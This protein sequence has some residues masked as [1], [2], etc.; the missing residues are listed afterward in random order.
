MAVG[1]RLVHF[2]V[3]LAWFEAIMGIIKSGKVVVLLAGRYA[4]RKAIVVKPFDEGSENRKFGHAIVAGI[5][6]YPR[7]VTKAMSKDKIKKRTK[8]K[9]FV[10]YVN[11]NHIMPTRY[12]VDI[13]LKKVVDESAIKASPTDVRKAV[14]KIFE[15][16]YLNQK[17]VKSEKKATG[18]K[19]FFE[20][21]RF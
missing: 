14:R 7:R 3:C 21:L 20:K 5:D 15:E 11:V 17:D 1:L 13:D 19:Y 18:V 6:R 10:K 12:Q 4:G 9:P 2:P 8:L 16:R